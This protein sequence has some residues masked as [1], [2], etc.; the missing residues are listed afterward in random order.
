MFPRFL[1]PSFFF[2]RWVMRRGLRSDRPV[3]QFIALF[4]VGRMPF[5]RMTAK[6]RGIYGRERPWQALAAAFFVGD[7]VKKLTE[8]E[9]EIVSTEQL[10]VGQT[11][12]V[13]RLPLDRRSS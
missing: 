10:K 7:V 12:S 4:Y 3:L 6:R 2:R 9:V 5:L 13:T 11:V 1:R 8:R